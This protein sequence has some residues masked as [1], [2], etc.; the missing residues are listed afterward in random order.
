MKNLL[1]LLFLIAPYSLYSQDDE[2]DLLPFEDEPLRES[3]ANYFAVAGG[4]T[5]DWFMLDDAKL[6]SIIQLPENQSFNSTMVMT[7]GHGFTGIPWVKNLRIGVL[8]IGGS[9]ETNVLD[10]MISQP[11]LVDDV[12]ARFN[13]VFSISM[14]G[15]SAHYGIVL[16]KNFAVVPGA[17]FG[18]GDMTM[19]RNIGAIN[20]P[21]PFIGATNRLEKA[22]YFVTPNV[23]FEFAL[24]NFLLLR[25][26]VSYNLTFAQDDDWTLNKNGTYNNNDGFNANGLRFGLGIFV[27]LINF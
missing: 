26:D 1:I 21:S 4:F 12:E 25:A 8:G 2:L 15:F 22:F 9:M 7:G 13:D 24:T 20:S 11:L 6:N 18:W 19:E 23:Q 17:N 10:T 5:V 3:T 27:G 16:F 14:F